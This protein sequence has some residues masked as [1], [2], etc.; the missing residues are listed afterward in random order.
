MKILKRMADLPE[1]LREAYV[2][3]YRRRY[4]PELGDLVVNTR[5]LF[6]NP[7]GFVIMYDTLSAETIPKG[8]P[9]ICVAIK[10]GVGYVLRLNYRIVT[11]PERLVI[12][13][14]VTSRSHSAR[15]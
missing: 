12:Y 3:W 15:G 4:I 8:T 6:S 14:R 13:L 9:M 2:S 5:D 10:D 1:I 7:A 11:L